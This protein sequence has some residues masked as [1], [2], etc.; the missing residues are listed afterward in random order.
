M[1]DGQGLKHKGI[2]EEL[3]LKI[4]LAVLISLYLFLIT[5]G[6]HVVSQIIIAYV[7]L[8][9]TFIY[10]QVSKEKSPWFRTL[11]VFLGMFLTLRYMYWRVTVSLSYS[12]FYDF[13]GTM[14]LFAAEIYSV[15]IY[16]IGVFSSLS[17]LERKVVDVSELKPEELP[18]VD[19]YIPTYS[20]PIDMVTDTALASLSIKY[21]KERVN[22][23]ILDDGGSDQKCNDKN[24]VSRERARERR[25]QFLE[26]SERI[27][28][29][30]IIR[31]KNLHAKAGNLN[32]ALEKTSGELILILD[33]DHIPTQQFLNNT[34]GWFLERPDMFLVQTPHCFY[35]PDPVERNLKM[36]GI[37]PGENQMFY[38]HIQKGHDFWESS[39]FCGS[40]AVLR[41]K[42]LVEVGG[43][44]GDTITEDA[45][46][47][48]GLHGRGYKSAFI[49][50]PM[51]RGRNPDT[52]AG[53]V[54]QRIRWTQGMIQIFILKNP[55]RMPGLKWYQRFSYLSA[56]G[57]WFFAFSRVVF[58]LSP[59]MYLYFGLHIYRA[60]SLD[61][62]GYTIPHVIAAAQVSSILY[63]KV[64]WSL[65]SEVYETAISFFTL[66][67]IIEVLIKPRDAQFEVT[68]K[69]ED[70]SKD[71]I[72]HLVYPFV[73][74]LCLIMLGYCC[75][76][77]RWFVYPDERYITVMTLAWNSFNLALVITGLAIS[78]EKGEK[79]NDVRMPSQESCRLRFSSNAFDGHLKD[80][81][82]GGAALDLPE[83]V[84]EDVSMLLKEETPQLTIS[85]MDD[86]SVTLDGDVLRFNEGQLVISFKNTEDDL[87]LRQ[88][89]IALVYGSEDRWIN[90]D[91]R[92]ESP[93]MLTTFW[94]ILRHSLENVKFAE[95]FRQTFHDLL[96]RFKFGV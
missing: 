13:I 54:L 80:V 51:V 68:P 72:S 86:N 4:E 88:K 8:T 2:S 21:P 87:D 18:S 77:Y 81:S 1:V 34:V 25:R 56:S 78:S 33:C 61:L 19:I 6:F 62:L 49:A 44:A 23:Y 28:V 30:Y 90:L 74:M 42:F 89:L 75:G 20:E 16:V 22:V 91:K 5:A 85:F 12:G 55:F 29:G 15:I 27:G 48:I 11:F 92:E 59:L 14:L 53:M 69:G 65:F 93:L 7:I 38:Q 24:P 50:I 94:M 47:A 76:I 31:P 96:R 39:F 83:E 60:D 52:F 64:R 84:W 45:E 37:I 10:T 17:P 40:A 73:A 95:I 43:I 79:R 36:F 82:M 63:S 71:F 57:F 67:A 9:A 58:M 32:E 35:N 46:T 70:V 3:V 41:R 26:V 66:P